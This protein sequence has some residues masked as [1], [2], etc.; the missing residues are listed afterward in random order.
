MV[1]KK[2]TMTR[3]TLYHLLFSGMI[4]KMIDKTRVNRQRMVY[5]WFYKIC[6]S[7]RHTKGLLRLWWIVGGKFWGLYLLT[8]F[9]ILFVE[10]LNELRKEKEKNRDI[11][12]LNFYFQVC[13]YF[14][15]WGECFPKLAEIISQG[16]WRLTWNHFLQIVSLRVHHV[17]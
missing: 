5:L 9:L 6:S 2:A 14:M 3:I 11:F 15:V 12:K 1:L 8:P 10:A 16:V 4:E 13:D 7:M 17:S